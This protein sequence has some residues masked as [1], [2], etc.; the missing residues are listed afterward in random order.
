[1]IITVHLNGLEKILAKLNDQVLVLAPLGN[2]LKRLTLL[3]EREARIAAPR[4][5]GNLQRNIVSA[6]RPLE[7]R[8]F[9]QGMAKSYAYVQEFGR[10]AGGRMPPPDALR[11]WARRHGFG[12][13]KGAL[14]VLARAI[15]RRG[16]KGRFFMHHAAQAVEREMPNEMRLLSHA[17]ESV[18]GR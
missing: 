3:G 18:W 15:A 4:D 5:I 1:M 2:T 11:S 13:S 16:T 8:V 10:K 17:V 7:G 12:T 14:F 9:I 6:L